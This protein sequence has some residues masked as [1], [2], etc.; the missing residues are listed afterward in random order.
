MSLL[1]ALMIGN[2]AD[3]VDGMVYIHELGQD[4]VS[5]KIS[6]G[7]FTVDPAHYSQQIQL[8]DGSIENAGWVESSWHI[9][10]LRGAQY[11][12]IAQYQDG[13]TTP[14]YIRT[15]KEDAKTYGNFLVKAIFPPRIVRADPTPI[16]DGA[17]FD[18]EI[19]FI[20]M[21]EV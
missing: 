8:G 3:G 14:L 21:I 15:L 18:F 4:E 16:E 6:E 17:V 12:A 11:A 7:A 1:D 20:Q 10:G 19:R 2:Y 5:P 13:I 9:N